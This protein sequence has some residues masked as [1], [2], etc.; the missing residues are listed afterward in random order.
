M[1]KKLINLRI[2]KVPF[3]VIEVVNLKKYRIKF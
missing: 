2:K 3:L 1:I